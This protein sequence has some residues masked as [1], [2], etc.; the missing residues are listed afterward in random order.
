LNGKSDEPL[1]YCLAVILCARGR[2]AGLSHPGECSRLEERGMTRGGYDR[3]ASL[4]ADPSKN[5][6]TLPASIIGFKM[7]IQD[8]TNKP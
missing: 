5:T 8:N 4:P 6:F 7:K 3:E 1:L 2:D